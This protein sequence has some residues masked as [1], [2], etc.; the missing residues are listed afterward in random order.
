MRLSIRLRSGAA[1][2]LHNLPLA[3]PDVGFAEQRQGLRSQAVTASAADFLIIG[4]DALRQIGVANVADIELVDPHA[5]SHRRHNDD[6]VIAQK[7]VLMGRSYLRF[8]T[9][10]IRKRRDAR[11][12]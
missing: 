7:L 8:E 9:C 2:A 5:E 12:A 1:V 6:A 11:F 4:L 10:V 3:Q